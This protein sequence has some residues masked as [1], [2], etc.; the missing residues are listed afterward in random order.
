MEWRGEERRA[1][2]ERRREG[3]QETLTR[4]K[5]GLDEKGV[6]GERQSAVREGLERG[7]KSEG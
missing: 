4:G 1:A 3:G 6:R 2:E 7:E 5:M